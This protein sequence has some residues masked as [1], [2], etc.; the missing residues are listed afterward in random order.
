MG[1]VP[2]VFRDAL[3]DHLMLPLLWR[4]H[5]LFWRDAWLSF[6]ANPPL[7]DLP[8]ALFASY[9]WDWF[10][11]VWHATGAL[12]VMLL[13]NVCMRRLHLTSGIRAGVMILWLTTPVVVNLCAFTYV[14][15]WL[16]AAAAGLS[17]L[18]M[19]PAWQSR[20][21]WLFGLCLGMA[22]LIKYNG[23]PLV[24][25]GMLA[26]VVRWHACPCCML[27]WIWRSSLACVFVASGWYVGNYLQ[28]GGALYPLGTQTGMGWLAYRIGAYGEPAWWA[29]LAPLRQFFWGEFGNP[30]LFDGMLQPLALLGVVGAYRLRR[31]PRAAAL[32]LMSMVYALFALQVGVR[33][34]YWLPGIVPLYPLAGYALFQM[35][36]WSAWVLAAGLVPAL[37]ACIVFWL[38]LAPWQFWLH[39]RDAYL[40]AHLADYP[41]QHWA[42][43]HLPS[44]A[45]VYLLWMAGRAYY[46]HRGYGADF[47][48]EGE[49]LRR[50]IQHGGERMF[51]HILMNRRLAERTLGNELG[52]EWEHWLHN[53]CLLVRQG[54]F[55]IRSL[56]PCKDESFRKQN[57]EQAFSQRSALR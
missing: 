23:L 42:E 57:Q 44:D 55:E 49:R 33:A 41:I 38:W 36:R 13:L 29:A 17:A 53:T 52:D 19:L 14:D 20:H 35:R 21:A 11:S 54:D 22:L 9:P 43:T 46:L 16:C 47:G 6:T 10:A 15:L 27:S 12:V 56:S 18:L 50:A 31:S 32:L 24:I 8:Y 3:N 4:K 48:R 51:T 40:S 39:G 7:A 30:V 37:S 26:L 25:A 5:G 34:R 45:K 28:L 2:P 1:L